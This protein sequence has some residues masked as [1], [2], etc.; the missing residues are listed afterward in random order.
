M[1]VYEDVIRVPLIIRGPGIQPRRVAATA[2]LVDVMPTVLEF[3]GAPVPKVDGTSLM[4][5][6]IGSKAIADH[7]TYSESM[8]PARFGRQPVRALRDGRYKLIDAVD[9]QLFDLDRDPLETRDLASERAP[10]AAAMS[11]AIGELDASTSTLIDATRPSA[12]P[13]ELRRR[14]AALGYVSGASEAD[15]RRDLKGARTAGSEH[16]R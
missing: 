16:L 10:L 4:P 13:P 12:V 15:S 5:A 2:S 9:R 3:V 8:Y 14:L 11:A 7:Q 1:Q 6:L